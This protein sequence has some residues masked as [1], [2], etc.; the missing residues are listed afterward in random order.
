MNWYDEITQ[1][2]AQ[3]EKEMENINTFWGIQIINILGIVGH[4]VSVK[5]T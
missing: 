5:T 3:R 4:K 1:S 2:I